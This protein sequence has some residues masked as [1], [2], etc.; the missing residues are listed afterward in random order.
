MI[1]IA[2]TEGKAELPLG[3]LRARLAAQ[4]V[5]Q[6]SVGDNLLEGDSFSARQIGVKLE[7]P[8][9]N[10][11]FTTAFT[12]ASG[13]TNLRAPWSGYPGY[14]SVQVQDF[15][16]AGETAFL[17]RI[18]YDVPWVEGLSA[19]ALAV[20]GNDPDG[21]ALRQNG[22]ISTFSGRLPRGS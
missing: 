20:V 17:F 10:F 8:L 11:L 18:G 6:S 12:H 16:R 2:Y 22:P 9:E 21:A 14:T 4:Y 13:D 3:S 1:N 15:N 7:L 19:Y 5:D